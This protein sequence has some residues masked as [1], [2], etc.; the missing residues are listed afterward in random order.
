VIS[1]APRV[2]EVSV[3]LVHNPY[4]EKLRQS[5]F[6][7]RTDTSEI[8]SVDRYVWPARPESGVLARSELSTTFGLVEAYV[9]TDPT[10][11]GFARFLPNL[12]P[13]PEDSRLTF[14]G[15]DVADDSL[16]SGLLNCEYSQDEISRLRPRWAPRLNDYHLFDNRSDAAD[17]R[18]LSNERVPEHAPFLVY[19]LWIRQGNTTWSPVDPAPR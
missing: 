3:R 17:F 12:G 10:E 1:D 9:C 7:L 16:I 2:V 19:Q 18:A 8:Y 13:L 11:Y 5:L 4:G 6:V 15:F 14:V